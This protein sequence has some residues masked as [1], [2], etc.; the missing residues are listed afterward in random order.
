MNL[1]GGNGL[2]VSFVDYM[3]GR[4]TGIYNQNHPKQQQQQ[5]LQNIALF[6]ILL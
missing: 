2:E 1:H 6:W 3:E 4:L 5:H